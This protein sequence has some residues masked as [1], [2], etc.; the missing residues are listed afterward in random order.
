MIRKLS[1]MVVLFI[2]FGL[3]VAAEAITIYPVDRAAILSGSRFDVKVEF[4]RA[5]KPGEWRVT[6][7]DKEIGGALGRQ[8][9]FIAEEKGIGKSALILR[10]VML[11]RPG[12]YRVT[13]SDGAS[14]RTVTWEV[15]GGESP[16]KA[17]NVILF[18]G[19][20]F[21]VAHRTAARILSKGI[22][23]GKYRGRLA[24]DE[25]PHMA[26]VGTSGVDS[27]ITDSANSASAYATGHKSSVNAMGVYAD[28][29]SDTLDDPRVETITSLAKRKLNMAVGVVTNTEVEDATPAAM[30]AHTRRRADYNV[31][32]KQFFE[33]GVDVL[34]GG[35]SANF[36]PKSTPGSR[37]QDEENYVAKFRQAGYSLVTSEREMLAAAAE[38]KTRKLLGLF[39]TGNMDGVLDR[40][41]LKKGTV[42]KFPNQPDLVEMTKA[43]LDVL[44]RNENGFVL[45]VESGLID[46][47]S[48]PLDWERAIMDTI[49]LDNAVRVAREFAARRNDTLIMVVADHSHGLSIVGTVDDNARGGEMRDKVGVYADAGYPNYPGPN[50]EGYPPDLNV[51]KRLAIFFA[52]FPDYYETFRPKLDGPFVPA[53]AG[54]DKT[55]VANPHYKDVPGA[56]LLTGILPRNAN[57]GVHTGED[58]VLTAMGPGAEM[59]H[60]FMDNTDLFRVM[61]Q[62]LGLAGK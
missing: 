5:L 55:Y 19:D 50:A 27:V 39:H 53:V 29:T 46:K 24:L 4:D 43:A 41:F 20:G 57:Q 44:S 30:V 60:G 61:A 6:V 22:T 10:D 36:L 18:I 32:V 34:M 58:V 21:S 45:M 35:G 51:S 54:P 16:R 49:M 23:E 62:A 25:M 37:R 47:Y 59:V 52:N 48:H 38:P 2:L 11:D 1:A 56:V 17:K 28:R 12:P 31:I 42:G 13:A 15:Y 8:A 9:D 33:S 26:L 7:N 40:K 3:A 14:T